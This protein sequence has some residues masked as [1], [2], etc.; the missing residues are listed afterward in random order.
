MPNFKQITLIGHLGK[1]AETKFLPSGTP[2]TI[3]SIAVT[4]SYKDKKETS[5]FNITF[6][7][8]KLTQYL[9]KGKPIMLIGNPKME[10]WE[11]D[12]KKHTALKVIADKI[13]FLGD[14]DKSSREQK[15]DS[16]GI[17]TYQSSYDPND[18]PF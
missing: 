16:V 17:E 6:F 9:T 13:V 7:S 5:W 4:E 14:G 1:D 12:G 18:V 10:T 15:Q 8:D 2:V 11:K 3:F